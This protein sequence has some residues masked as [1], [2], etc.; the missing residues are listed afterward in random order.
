MS[1]G[2]AFHRPFDTRRLGDVPI[3]ETLAAAAAERAAIAAFLG[4]VGLDRLEADLRL[5]RWSAN[6]VAIEGRLRAAPVQACVVTLEPVHQ[7]VDE[8]FHLTFLPGTDRST[9]P[10][11]I[12]EAEIIVAFDED[13]PPDELDGPILDL[14]PLVVEQLA[15]AL[16][17]YPRSEGATLAAADDDGDGDG[18]ATPFAALSRLRKE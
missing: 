7:M 13:D 15:L 14:G 5:E 9:V 11:T 12:A 10:R 3:V 1:T 8:A 18:V 2:P 6:G 16:D 17:P 4:I